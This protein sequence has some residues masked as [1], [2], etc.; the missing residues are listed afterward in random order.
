MRLVR[1]G[2][3]EEQQNDATILSSKADV[4]RKLEANHEKHRQTI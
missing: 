1:F 4:S 2:V 3:K